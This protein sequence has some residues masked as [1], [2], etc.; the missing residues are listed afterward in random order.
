M[1]TLV[2]FQTFKACSP[3][4]AANLTRPRVC[5]PPPVHP[6]HSS[7]A[8]EGR[9]CERRRSRAVLPAHTLPVKMTHPGGARH[10]ATH[11]ETTARR[12]DADRGH[13]G[14]QMTGKKGLKAGR[15]AAVGGRERGR[16]REQ[17]S[18]Q[19]CSSAVGVK[20]N[21]TNNEMSILPTSSLSL[22]L[23]RL[24]SSGPHYQCT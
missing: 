4:K 5:L 20:E 22:T 6:F 8:R 18:E 23:Q 7:L 19:S 15:G 14:L 17:M 2:F 12:R 13:G 9:R 10:Y 21:A 16:K 1:R 3:V 24:F 11:S